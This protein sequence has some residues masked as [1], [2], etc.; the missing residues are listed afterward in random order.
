MTTMHSSAVKKSLHGFMENKLTLLTSKTTVTS[1]CVFWLLLAWFW[2]SHILTT[3]QFSPKMMQLRLVPQ[4]WGSQE[5]TQVRPQAEQPV[6]CGC[7]FSSSLRNMCQ[8]KCLRHY[9]TWG[10]KNT[11]HTQK[12]LRRVGGRNTCAMEPNGGGYVKLLLPI[13][14]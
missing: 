5:V 13:C 10:H 7:Y 12:L 4:H 14:I 6:L 3:A 8:I 9:F 1:I 2:P 11:I